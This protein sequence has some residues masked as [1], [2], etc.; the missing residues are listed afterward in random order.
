MDTTK[1]KRNRFLRTAALCAVLALLSLS[2]VS[3]TFAKYVTKTSG[4]DSARVAAWGF[5]DSATI[6]I[7]DLFKS[8]YTTGSNENVKATVDVIAPG[9]EGSV[10]FSLSYEG[11]TAPEVA[12]SISVNTTGSEIG[13][14]IKSNSNIQWKL[15]SG[16]YGTWDSLLTAIQMLSGSATGTM[17]YK[18][19][20]LPTQLSSSTHTVSWRWTFETSGSGQASQDAADT[21]LGAKAVAS[22]ET[23]K[24]VVSVTATQID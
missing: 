9:T 10:S 17:S 16:T 15:D 23:V 4:T 3:G 5:S 24:L 6:N 21:A 2:V 14:N 8:S 12:Y 22:L 20:E 1:V 7:G 19:G 18:P 11:A 13:P